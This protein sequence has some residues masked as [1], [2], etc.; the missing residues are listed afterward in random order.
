MASELSHTRNSRFSRRLWIGAVFFLLLAAPGLWGPNISNILKAHGAL[1]VLPYACAIAPILGILS[2]LMF[3]S[4][5]DR[6]VEAQKL[7]GVLS[8]TGAVFLYLAFA[9]LEW[10][11]DPRWY[12]VFQACNAYIAAPMWALLVKVALVHSR[13]TERD[14]PLFRVWGTVGWITA[15]VVVSWWHL[16]ASV[17]A[18][19]LAS[20]VRLMIGLASFML[21]ATPPV[22]DAAQQAVKKN[23][24]SALG[25]DALG[26]LKDKSLQVYFI[27]SAT[28]AIPMASFY[29]YG[30]KHLMELQAMAH[31]STGFT[32]WVV[33]LLPGPSAQMTIG[34]FLEIAA[35]LLMSW[36]GAKVRLKSLMVLAMV[37]GVLRFVLFAM[38]GYYGVITWMWLGIALHGPIYTFFSLTGQIFVDRRVAPNMRAQAQSLTSLL[39]SLGGSTGALLCGWL[40]ASTVEA[41]VTMAWSIFWLILAAAVMLIL[42]F[43]VTGFRRSVDQDAVEAAVCSSD[44]QHDVV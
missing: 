32:H 20:V 7:L 23:W 33:T 38:A 27:T 35:M 3:T 14:F 28:L 31:A 37:L 21:P 6:R 1:W 25:L 8:I 44:E 16:D 22:I 11:W 41:K 5:A 34:Q 10:G 43:F 17:N 29:M 12:I 30:T 13:N 39:A 26:L 24:K 36:W 4:L 18:G 9:C 42:L 15:G 40:Y 2:G 19:K